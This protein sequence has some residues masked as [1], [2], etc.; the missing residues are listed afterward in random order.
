MGAKES[1]SKITNNRVYDKYI[2]TLVDYVDL[3][4]LLFSKILFIVDKPK[5]F[6]NLISRKN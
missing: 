3:V 5:E 2:P 1:K 4:L 6:K